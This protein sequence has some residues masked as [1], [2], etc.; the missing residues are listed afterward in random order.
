[1]FVSFPPE[2][3]LD[4]AAS[5]AFSGLELEAPVIQVGQ[6]H[7]FVGA[8]TKPLGTPLIFTKDIDSNP[9]RLVAKIDQLLMCSAAVQEGRPLPRRKVPAPKRPRK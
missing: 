9:L 3:K 7:F 4:P 8:W 6:E 2:F 1:V 5:C